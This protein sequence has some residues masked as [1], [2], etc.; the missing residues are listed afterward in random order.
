M[1]TFNMVLGV[2]SLFLTAFVAI[3]YAYLHRH[4]ERDVSFFFAVEFISI[5]MNFATN[6]GGVYGLSWLYFIIDV[7]F[8]AL[9]WA[10]SVEASIGFYKSIVPWFKQVFSNTSLIGWQILSLIVFPCGIALHF[11]WY[12]TKSEL[13]LECGKMAMWGILCW[14]FLLWMIL[15][16]AL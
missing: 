11:A 4:T 15:G 12:R 16:L 2:I 9:G 1:T 8:I 14:G 3:Y 7:A 6:A 10:V 5:I 13:A